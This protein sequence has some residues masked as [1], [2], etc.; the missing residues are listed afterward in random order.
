MEETVALHTNS[1]MLGF[2]FFVDT[3]FLVDTGNLD[4]LYAVCYRPRYKWLVNPLVPG[5]YKRNR[6]LPLSGPRR[7]FKMEIFSHG[8]GNCH[9]M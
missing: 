5:L 6:V 9:K 2:D 4:I 3:D 8:R 1:T 7:G